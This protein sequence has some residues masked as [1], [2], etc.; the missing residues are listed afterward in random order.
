MEDRLKLDL[1][2]L[3]DTKTKML[4]GGTCNDY[5]QYRVICAE[6]NIIKHVVSLLDKYEE[7]DF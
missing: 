7:E 6:I 2:D 1:K 5:M 3:L 4:V